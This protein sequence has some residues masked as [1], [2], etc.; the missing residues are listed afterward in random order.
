MFAYN[1][2]G[3][4]ILF[5]DTGLAIWGG[6]GGGGIRAFAETS[7]KLNCPSKCPGRGPLWPLTQ[8]EG[9]EPGQRPP[10]PCVQ[11][12]GRPVG[13]GLQPRKGRVGGGQIKAAERPLV[14][15]P[16]L[17]AAQSGQIELGRPKQSRFPFLGAG[18]GLR[19]TGTP[20][21]SSATPEGSAESI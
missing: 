21:S 11:P 19:A 2:C 8:P 10:P 13:A 3:P 17:G 7:G 20:V 5:L 4:W 18:V 15:Q 9:G 6:G 12:P 16:E 14:S 1:V